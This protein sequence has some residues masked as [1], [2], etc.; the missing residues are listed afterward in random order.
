MVKPDQLSLARQLD[1]VLKSWKKSWEV[2]VQGQYLYK[3]EIM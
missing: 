1:I 3:Y 2:L